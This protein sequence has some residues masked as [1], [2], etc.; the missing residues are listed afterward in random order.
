MPIRIAKIKKSDIPNAGKDGEK[1]DYLHI[2]GGN[3]K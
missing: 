1:L 3:V 2:A